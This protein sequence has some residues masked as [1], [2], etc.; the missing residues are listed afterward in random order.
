MAPGVSACLL[1][2][3]LERALQGHVRHFLPRLSASHSPEVLA[4]VSEK[5]CFQTNIWELGGLTARDL[6]VTSGHFQLTKLKS[7]LLYLYWPLLRAT[8]NLLLYLLLASVIELE[9]LI[10]ELPG[11]SP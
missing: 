4:S 8:W 7:I 5:V 11:E 3:S 9:S 1:A 6:I 10:R 2:I